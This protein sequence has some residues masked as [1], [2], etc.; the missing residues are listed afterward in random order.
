MSDL[1]KKIIQVMCV[2][3]SFISIATIIIS[4][5]ATAKP[6]YMGIC[7][8]YATIT[9]LIWITYGVLKILDNKYK[10]SEKNP[11]YKTALVV[12]EQ[13]SLWFVYGF[14]QIFYWIK[15]LIDWF[16]KGKEISG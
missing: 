12:F 4:P 8:A 11:A 6:V 10:Y 14:K 16:K 1:L 3:L 15:E 2:V 13:L 5:F 7:I 9:I